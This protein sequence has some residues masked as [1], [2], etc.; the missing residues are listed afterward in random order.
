MP[1]RS[2]PPSS[3]PASN[4]HP[5][6][7]SKQPSGPPSKQPEGNGR[8]PAIILT[9]ILCVAGI[10]L[11]ITGLVLILKYVDG[12]NEWTVGIVLLT[13][14]GVFLI[15]AIALTI[16]LCAGLAKSQN[17][18]N[19]NQKP[20]TPIYVQPKPP[21]KKTV[22]MQTSEPEPHK[23]TPRAKRTRQEPQDY[24]HPLAYPTITPY[25]TPVATQSPKPPAKKPV[26]KEQPKM[27]KPKEKSD[28][29][30]KRPK[31]A[32]Q[33]VSLQFKPVSSKDPSHPV[34]VHVQPISPDLQAITIQSQPPQPPPPPRPP[35]DQF[36]PVIVQPQPV[37]MQAN[38]P[39]P[40][41]LSPPRPR[42]PLLRRGYGRSMYGGHPMGYPFY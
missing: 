24:A 39:D 8:L 30:K 29:E 15:V 7:T 27:Q 17:K 9:C 37:L 21:P 33:P 22:S 31:P 20:P 16:V 35:V 28:K 5:D 13:I 14:A 41:Y 36:I 3:H 38:Q 1:S 26:K 40:M 4:N 18:T 42:M 12:S 34:T 6:P 23:E 2:G 32:E 10:V 11:A 19:P 25:P